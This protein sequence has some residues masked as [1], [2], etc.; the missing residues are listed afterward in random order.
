MREKI[1]GSNEQINVDAE[2]QVEKGSGDIKDQE[3]NSIMEE[4]E[5]AFKKQEEIDAKVDTGE[6]TSEQAQAEMRKIQEEV[7]DPLLYK[8][9]DKLDELLENGTITQE[10]F[11]ANTNRIISPGLLD[12]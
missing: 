10:Q 11:D 1:P 4:I 8:R 5:S 2:N 9:S 12:Y 6:L 7:V 3:Y